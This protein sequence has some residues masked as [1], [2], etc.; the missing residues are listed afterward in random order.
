MNIGNL[1]LKTGGG[2]GSPAMDWQFIQVREI[3][4]TEKTRKPAGPQSLNAAFFFWEENNRARTKPTYSNSTL[5]EWHHVSLPSHPNTSSLKQMA[6]SHDL[7]LIRRYLVTRGFS[8]LLWW[9]VNESLL[10]SKIYKE[11]WIRVN[12]VILF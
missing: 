1:V 2:G 3:K 7:G 4:N 5:C 6:F 11:M 9:T 8:N 12:H 10:A